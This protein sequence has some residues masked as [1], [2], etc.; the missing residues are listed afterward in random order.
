MAYFDL[1]VGFSCNNNCIHC[2]VAGKRKT[3]D[4]DTQEIKSI[5][6]KRP[7][8]DCIGFTGGEP[9]IR[10]DFIELAR[11]AKKKGYRVELQTNGTRF[12]DYNFAK[13]ISNYMDNI[14]IAIHSYKKSVHNKIVQREGMYEK[15]I[16]G[17][18]NIVKLKITH[19][20]QTVISKLNAD[21]LKETYDFIQSIS[22]GCRMQM[23][24]PH[25]MGNA[26]YNKE[27]VVPR[28]SKI[29][30]HIYRALKKYADI[31]VTEAIPICYLYPYHNVVENV[32]EKIAR[33]LKK[34]EKKGIDYSRGEKNIEGY[35]SL[36]FNDKR[37]G[38]ECG[39]CIFNNRCAGVW[40]EYIEF[41]RDDLDLHPFY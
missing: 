9:T 22:P 37:K 2:V 19:S 41:Y 40:K 18:K 39:R 34:E 11:Y 32:D 15:T 30:K 4:L 8:E 33:H 12:S 7:Q 10:K 23:T 21:H 28:Y 36:M 3:R 38:P 17:F 31:L 16:K 14:L 29:K 24:F 5:I 13:E 27:K 20:T 1:K 6:K 35:L 26:Y 25:P